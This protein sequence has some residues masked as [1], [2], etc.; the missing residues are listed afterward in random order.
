VS[1]ED[2][3][4]L[5]ALY[6]DW[7]RGDYGSA[8]LFADDIELS[9]PTDFP[10]IMIE[11]GYVGFLSAM[12]NWLSSWEHF[13][14]EAREF[15]DLGDRVVALVRWEGIS[16]VSGS[17]VERPGAHLWSFRDGKAVALQLCRDREEALAVAAALG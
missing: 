17:K 11:P 15:I 7:A 13:T 5:R 9:V 2:V 3:A 10:D 6:E 12:R 1:A 16:K 4:A 14:V 8:A